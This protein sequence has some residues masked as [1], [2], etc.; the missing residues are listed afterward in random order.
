MY[1]ERVVIKYQ[2][3]YYRW[4]CSCCIVTPWIISSVFSPYVYLIVSK[5]A[6]RCAWIPNTNSNLFMTLCLVRSKNLAIA[7]IWLKTHFGQYSQKRGILWDKEKMVFLDKWPLKRGSI[8]MK[9]SIT[10]QEKGDLLIQLS[11]ADF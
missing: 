1:I 8:H 9:C 4:P 6:L 2:V 10:G 3:S 5:E 11:W 7:R